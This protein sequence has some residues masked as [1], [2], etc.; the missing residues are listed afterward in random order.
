LLEAARLAI[1]KGEEGE[2]EEEE[3]E[4]EDHHQFIRRSR[5]FIQKAL[6]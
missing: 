1:T 6:R 3:E 5:R 2:E 4:E